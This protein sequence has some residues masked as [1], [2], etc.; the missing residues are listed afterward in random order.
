MESGPAPTANTFYE[1][2][3]PFAR[4]YPCCS[5]NKLQ[6]SCEYIVQHRQI[7]AVSL[8]RYM[9]RVI[10]PAT[11]HPTKQFTKWTLLTSPLFCLDICRMTCCYV[12]GCCVSISPIASAHPHDGLKEEI[13]R[14]VI[15]HINQAILKIAVSL[16]QAEVHIENTFNTFPTTQN[17]AQA[18]TPCKMTFAL[19]VSPHS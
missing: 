11:C 10:T 15:Q 4:S 17:H 14:R 18:S 16:R 19:R 5:A 3:S 7:A 8:V 9:P 13:T 12:F 6:R 1:L 2:E